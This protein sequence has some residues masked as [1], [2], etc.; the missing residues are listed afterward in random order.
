MSKLLTIEEAAAFLRCSVRTIKRRLA[1]GAIAR[2]KV[3]NR[4]LIEQVEI[5]KYLKRNKAS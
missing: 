1:E 3:G 2:Y 4:C 5:E